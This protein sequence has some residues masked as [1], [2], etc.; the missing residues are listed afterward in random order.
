MTVTGAQHFTGSLNRGV[1]C[2][3]NLPSSPGASSAMLSY[4]STGPN[5]VQRELDV[6]A[7][8]G[9]RAFPAPPQSQVSIR[10]SDYEE[11][12]GGA[13]SDYYDWSNPTSGTLTVDPGARSGRI[14]IDVPYSGDEGRKHPANLYGPV[15]VTASWNCG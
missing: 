8:V 10:Y 2:N 7:P 15:H 4:V 12:G 1:S 9:T 14:E 13:N 6:Q 3:P 5:Q 11:A